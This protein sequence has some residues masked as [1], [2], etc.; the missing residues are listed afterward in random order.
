MEG[1]KLCEKVVVTEFLSLD[2][3]AEDP[4]TF[5]T[6]WDDDVMDAY[7]TAAID[8]QDAVILGRRSYDEWAAFWP[9][10]PSNRS[11]ASSMRS[12]STSPPQHRSL[13]SGP[14]RA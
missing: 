14:P 11:P 9:E 10:P 4:D 1:V 7:M 13:S 2:G 12:R 6:D 3:V 5:A 8:A